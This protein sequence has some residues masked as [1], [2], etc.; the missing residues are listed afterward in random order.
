MKAT[1]NRA[2]WLQAVAR[3]PGTLQV[4]V[5]SVM[6]IR[7]E[8]GSPGAPGPVHR[9]LLELK[10]VGWHQA[11]CWWIWHIPGV[12]GPVDNTVA[13]PDK[14]KHYMPYFLNQAVA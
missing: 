3:T 11:G 12:D 10:S 6:D 5:Q 9:A 8:Q 1:Y 2:C 14:F 4:V 7:Q 13:D